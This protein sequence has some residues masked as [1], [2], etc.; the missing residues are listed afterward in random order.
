MGAIIGTSVGWKP[1]TEGRA[2]TMAVEPVPEGYQTVTPYLAVQGVGQLIDFLKEVFGAEEK[3]RMPGEGGR[4]AHAEVRIGDSMVMMGE[5]QD[6]SKYVPAMLHVYMPA[7]DDVYARAVAA[8]A[9][10]VQE[11]ADQFYGDRT[12]A[13]QDAS[14]NQWFIATHVKDVTAQEL[15]QGGAGSA[16]TG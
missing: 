1:S 8:G 9:T 16:G 13:V 5:P 7:V 14:G 11:P 10:S 2:E 6:P 12:A 3:L 15:E 4:L